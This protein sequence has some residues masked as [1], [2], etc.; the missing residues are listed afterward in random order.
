MLGRWRIPRGKQKVLLQRMEITNLYV[1]V[2]E[3]PLDKEAKYLKNA[4]DV[5]DL[6]RASMT[7]GSTQPLT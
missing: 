5:Y 1:N 2:P 3:K 7:P 6:L 4:V